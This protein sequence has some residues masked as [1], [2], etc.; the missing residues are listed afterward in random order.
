MA[1][2]TL[3]RA[4]KRIQT[5]KEH[6]EVIGVEHLNEAQYA[7]WRTLDFVLTL[8]DEERQGSPLQRLS[9]ERGG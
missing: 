3:D 7:R 5:A 1:Q 4:T 8:I 2:T 6:M 9:N